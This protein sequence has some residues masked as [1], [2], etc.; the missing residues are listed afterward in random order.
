LARFIIAITSA[1]LF[2]RSSV[3]LDASAA[4]HPPQN[5]PYAPAIQP[6]SRPANLECDPYQPEN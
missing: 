1:F 2:A 6:L 3:P 5:Y 4:S